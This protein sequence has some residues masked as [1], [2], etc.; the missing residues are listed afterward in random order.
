MCRERWE[1]VREDL[2]RWR[3]ALESSRGKTE[4]R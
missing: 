2:E 1:Q 4:H 3:N